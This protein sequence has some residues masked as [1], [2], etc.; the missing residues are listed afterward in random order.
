MM[1][2]IVKKR[3]KESRGGQLEALVAAKGRK[4]TCERQKIKDKHYK[5]GG[6][7]VL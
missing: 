2:A 5:R 6:G 3:R 7:G 1:A 4:N